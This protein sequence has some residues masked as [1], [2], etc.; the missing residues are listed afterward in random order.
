[1]PFEDTIPYVKFATTGLQIRTNA[2]GIAETLS[3]S[4]KMLQY[5]YCSLPVIAPVV[6]PAHHRENI[7]YYKY[8]D[9]CSIRECIEHALNFDRN[10]FSV[11]IKS[12]NEV[13]MELTVA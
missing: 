6:M 5:S 1:M 12:W 4:L 3:D 11:S 10:E 8:G 2:D 9:E 7:F 13:A